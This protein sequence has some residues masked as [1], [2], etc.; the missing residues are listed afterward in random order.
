MSGDWQT[1]TR[2]SKRIRTKLQELKAYSGYDLYIDRPPNPLSIFNAGFDKRLGNQVKVYH[3]SVPTLWDA[4]MHG[5]D[6]PFLNIFTSI[7]IVFI[8]EVILSLIALLFAYDALAGERERGTL[9][10]VLAQQVRRGHILLAKYISAMLCL[11]V[12]LL[13]SLLL[14]MILLT[15]SSTISLSIDDFLRIGGILLA[16]LAYLSVFYLIGMLIS[17]VSRRTSTALMFSIFI[18]GFLVLVYPNM[19]LAVM[20]PSNVPRA[21]VDSTMNQMEQIWEEFDRERK[22]FLINDPV[23]GESIWFKIGAIGGSHEHL[24]KR[25]TTL[26]V[27][28]RTGLN[29]EDINKRSE[30]QVPHAQ[31]YFRFLEPRVINTAEKTWLVRERGLENIFIH[32]ASIDRILLKFSPVGI[33][34][35]A[36]QAWA[37]TDLYGIRDFFRA[38]RQYR[39]TVIDYFYDTKV[40]GTR[41]WFAGDKRAVDWN[42]LP[43]FSFKRSDIGIHTKRA[44]PDVCLLLIINVTLFMA[45]FFIFIKSE[46]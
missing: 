1:I 35:S 13:M 21:Q 38:A 24:V 6:N 45:I 16:S 28:F 30:P 11:I 2:L 15:T 32:P 14:A 39:Q 27:H 25:A 19:I 37:G 44:L 7:D 17:A 29:L 18:W 12:P 42:A 46:V 3:A 43:Q 34:D 4:K 20:S 5:S 23:P 26:D 41:Q 10:L 36:T 40:F 9:R 22:D 33:Y 8:F 31:S